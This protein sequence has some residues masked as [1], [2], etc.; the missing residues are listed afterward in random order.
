MSVAKL[1]H[2]YF[3]GIGGIGMS[4]LARYYNARGVK[5]SGYDLRESTLTK[6]LV[7][8]GIDVHY[9]DL[10]ERIPTDIDLAIYTPAVPKDFGEL[11]ALEKS[12][13][14]LVKRAQALGLISQGHKTLGVAGTHG[15]TTTSTMAAY[16]MRE[17]DTDAVAFLGGISTNYK[18]NYLAGKG[19]WLVVEAD[20][21]DR[22]FLSLEPDVAIIS[23]IEADHLDIYGEESAFE[24]SFRQ[25]IGKVDPAGVVITKPSIAE[26]LASSLKKVSV[27]TY[28]C[29]DASAAWNADQLCVVDGAFEFRLTCPLG[30]F[31]HIRLMMPGAHNVENA[32]AALAAV[33]ATGASLEMA[34]E[35][36]SGFLGVARRFERLG[37]I[38]RAVAISDYA[39]HPTEVAASIRAAKE[40]FEGY[41]VIG[42]FQ[43]HLFSRTRDFADEF[44]RALSDLGEVVL[45]EIYPAREQP[46]EGV[47][48]MTI[49][50]NISV[51]KKYLA[52]SSEAPAL[53]KV[54]DGDVLLFMGAGDIDGLARSL[55]SAK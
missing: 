45:L 19:E 32:V 24:D 11:V 23:Y 20:E 6:A 21:Y 17:L 14:P 12:P 40:L 5:V 3:V 29:N 25:F 4:A 28:G 37:K 50:S 33:S 34:I 31:E 39:H 35:K 7:A 42:I 48:P 38:G 18:T 43:P 30:V 16:L 41:R 26:K 55:V 46:I 8:E 15:K 36:L 44:A 13:V 51:E 2:V 47:T 9:E 27:V 54:L 53:L 10:P 22:S 52:A 49:F 1:K